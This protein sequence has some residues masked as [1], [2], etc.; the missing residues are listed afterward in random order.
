[1]VIDGSKEPRA[2]VQVVFG[3]AAQAQRCCPVDSDPRVESAAWSLW[4][5]WASSRQCLVREELLMAR[6]PLLADCEQQRKGQP[7]FGRS[8]LR[9]LKAVIHLDRITCSGRGRRGTVE[10]SF[11]VR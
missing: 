3:A 10:T 4:S 1:M 5:S 2:A 9:P 6:R 7:E 11:V 8:G